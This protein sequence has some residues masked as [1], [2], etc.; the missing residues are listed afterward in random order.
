MCLREQTFYL[1]LIF[2]NNRSGSGNSRPAAKVSK[3]HYVTVLLET[4]FITVCLC[5]GPNMALTFT[6]QFNC[7]LPFFLL[8]LYAF[9]SLF[10]LNS[11]QILHMLV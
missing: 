5:K 11:W 3:N 2:R 9:S 4:G 6:F 8:Y 1:S 7:P 10:P